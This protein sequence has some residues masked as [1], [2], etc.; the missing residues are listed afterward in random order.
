MSGRPNFNRTRNDT[1]FPSPGERN[2]TRFPPPW[3]RNQ[4]ND[5]DF[6]PNRDNDSRHRRDPSDESPEIIFYL[7]IT[8]LIPSIICFLFLFYNFLRLSHLRLKSSN[9]L[10][11]CLLSIN[12]I[13]VSHWFVHYSKIFFASFSY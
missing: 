8:L 2:D 9:F 10:I 12:F 6:W 4:S 5:S 7:L 1:R 13:H 11:I 3:E